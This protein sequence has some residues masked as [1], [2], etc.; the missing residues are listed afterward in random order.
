MV[1]FAT[2]LVSVLPH[3]GRMVATVES[4]FV[5]ATERGMAGGKLLKAVEAYAGASGSV[6]ILYSAPA[7][8]EFEKFLAE[9]EEYEWTNSVY[10]RRL[11]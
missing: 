5:S 1:G 3:Y 4:L 7:G 2:V 6:A 8:G 11:A 10:C 9:R